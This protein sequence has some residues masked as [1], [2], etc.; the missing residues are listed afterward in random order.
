MS[1]QLRFLTVSGQSCPAN[2]IIYDKACD[3]VDSKVIVSFAP[4]CS[5]D[6]RQGFKAT[7]WNNMTLAGDPVADQQALPAP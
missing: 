1:A 6:G 2:K 7:Y 4:E 5:I 3:I